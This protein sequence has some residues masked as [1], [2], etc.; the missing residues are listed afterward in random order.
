MPNKRKKTASIIIIT[1]D[2]LEKNF[3]KLLFNLDKNKFVQKKPIF[4]RI[5]EV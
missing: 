1:H 4:I 2:N 3:T 5:E